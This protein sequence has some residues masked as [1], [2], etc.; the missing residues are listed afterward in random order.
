[1]L[2]RIDD[3]I[4]PN[5]CEVIEF[6]DPQRFVYPIYKNGRTSLTYYPIR[7]YKIIIND[8]I[9]RA[10]TIDVILRDPLERF[11][12]GVNTFVFNTKKENPALDIDTIFYFTN[13]YLFLNRHYA[14]QISWLTN[15]SRFIDADTKLK[16]YDMK[17]LDK[18]TTEKSNPPEDKILT[19]DQIFELSTNIHNEMYLRIDQLLVKLIGRELCFTEI[20]NYIKEQD[21]IAFQKLKCIAP[22]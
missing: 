11:I 4:Y 15:L 8:Q 19:S 5:R 16:F 9:K 18:L 14:P 17:E 1:M 3:I 6:S 20:L 21:P 22:D 13:N 2:S 7:P 10:S 12:S